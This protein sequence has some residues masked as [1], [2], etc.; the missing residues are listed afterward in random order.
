M[1]DEEEL[2][3]D[4]PHQMADSL[5]AAAPEGINPELDPSPEEAEALREFEKHKTALERLRDRLPPEKQAEL[6]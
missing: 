4:H 5:P 1:N 2:N 6:N 3:L